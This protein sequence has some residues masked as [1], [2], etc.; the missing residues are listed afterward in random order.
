M[1]AHPLDGTELS[2]R[3]LHTPTPLPTEATAI[4]TSGGA[5]C[6]RCLSSPCVC[7]G[8]VCIPGAVNDSI[9]PMWFQT[10]RGSFGLWCSVLDDIA[11]LRRVLDLIRDTR[12]L[13]VTPSMLRGEVSLPKASTTAETQTEAYTAY[14]GL[15]LQT[16]E[17]VAIAVHPRLA[18]GTQPLPEF[19]GAVRFPSDMRALIPDAN[20][21]RF[22]IDIA[23]TNDE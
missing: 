6:V 19:R 3:L 17:T 5:A 13:A 23:E 10:E 11:K 20:L 9:A 2:R 14:E 12:L 4:T 8:T 18:F 1:E 15:T 16:G 22:S 21:S 7:S